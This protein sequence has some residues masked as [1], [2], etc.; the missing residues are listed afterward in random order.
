MSLIDI[1]AA[2]DLK[3]MRKERGLSPEDLADEIC[4][5]AA[6]EGWGKR[7]TVDAHTIRRI[8]RY[9][10]VPGDRVCFVLASY[11]GKVPHEVWIPHNAVRAK[12]AA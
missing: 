3:R 12:A 5:V 10:H 6:R 7:G 8:E 2:Q 1:Y 9:G 4:L 11:F